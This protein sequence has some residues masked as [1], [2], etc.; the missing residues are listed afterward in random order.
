METVPRCYN[1]SCQK[2]LPQYWGMADG[3]RVRTGQL[4]SSEWC[5]SDD[6][7]RIFV[8]TQKHFARCRL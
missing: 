3:Y 1:P 5:A 7:Q 4:Y 6:E 2:P 8:E